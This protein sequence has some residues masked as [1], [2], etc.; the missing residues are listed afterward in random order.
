MSSN[1]Q[2][3]ETNADSVSAELALLDELPRLHAAVYQLFEAL[4]NDDTDRH[5][6]ASILDH[7]PSLAAKLVGL[8]NSAYFSRASRVNGVSDAIFVI[9][10]RTVRS[11]A[12]AT[13]LQEPFAN[14][15]CP[16]FHTGR[17]WLQAVL[18]AHVA[19]ELAKKTPPV[20]ELSPDEAYLSG[21]LH[22]I[23]ILALAHLFPQDMDRVLRQGNSPSGALA[24]RIQQQFGATHHTVGAALLRRWHLP[25]QFTRTTEH[26]TNP[27]Y[28]GPDW[29]ACR[30]IAVAHD[31]A[32]R[33]IHQDDNHDFDPQGLNLLGIKPGDSEAVAGNCLEQLDAFSDLAE[34]IS[35]EKP[36]F[37]DPDIIA[38]AAVDLKDRLV[39]TIESLSSL[40]ALTEINV[41]DRTEEGVLRGALKVL[42]ANQDMQR[43]S[44]FLV[45]GDELLNAAGLSWSEQNEINPEK[46]LASV[47]THRFR[48]GEGLIGLAAKT[49]ETQHCRDCT[50]DPRFKHMQA[51]KDAG[52]G[53]II[54]VP[55][56]FHGTTL[57]V[58]NI[59]HRE[60]NIFNEW[61]ERF[62]YVFCNMLGQLIKSNRLLRKMEHEIEQRTLEL[63]VALERAESLSIL[64][65]LTGVHNRRYFISNFSTLIEQ[66]ARYRQKLALL[67]IDVDDFKQIN[68][69]YG[70]LEGDR[71]LKAIAN[72][73]KHCARGADI[74]AR[75]GGEE[76]VI[77]LQDTDCEG[78]NQVAGRI[79]EQ[80]RLLSCGQGEQRS[81]I[82]ASLGLSCYNKSG[83]MPVK[84]PEQWIQEAD[85][86]LYR[87]KRSGKNR[88]SVYVADC[89]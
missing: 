75:F 51:K 29:M 4:S 61:D 84:T 13:A 17:F 47:A 26:Y 1:K 50:V 30:L 86:A 60:P 3:S 5:Q 39:D 43:C 79:L 49:G 85:D 33:V 19:K 16:A 88:I 37:F 8:A 81:G 42:M 2:L 31:W 65:G 80:I 57:G 44:I 73:L 71:I 55:I 83:D 10:F 54:S 62:L 21:L 77:A 32:D 48:V 14:N 18:T 23:G 22:G 28:Q 76:F 20:L 89:H 34:L 63:Q 41:Q 66:C 24:E 59:S 52:L 72:I 9:G 58:L 25:E 38:D 53:S 36:D 40:S 67:M 78:A 68:D 27:G 64:D 70:H 7:C 15:K 69:T 56:C 35:G 87:A 11:L 74:I 46:P 12:T 45:E 6:L 82:T